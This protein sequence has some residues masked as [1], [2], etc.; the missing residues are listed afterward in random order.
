MET[1][2]PPIQKKLQSYYKLH[3]RLQKQLGEAI[4]DFSLINQGDHILIGL[5][6]GKDSLA[7]LN[8]LGERMSKS[9]H[10]FSLEAIHVRMSNIN[11]V[12]DASYLKAECDKWEIP[13]HVVETRFETDRDA[14]RTPCFLCSWNRR[15]V[16]CNEAQRCGCNKI[17][18]GH[19]QDDI[20]RTAL[21]NLTFCGTFST[22][23]VRIRMRK[24]D[25]TIIR[26]LARM[27]E[28]DLKQWAS[29]QHYQ[30]VKKVCPYDAASNR[31]N[32]LQ[33]TAALE[34]LTPDYRYNLWHALLKA[35]ALVEE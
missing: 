5:S 4:K 31:T 9:N 23:P 33:V 24:F 7:L 11:Y 25:M 35:G 14:K 30:P 10:Y 34:K 29:L 26:P 12:S 6:G 20:L 28:K 2:N 3:H 21:M 32:I 17:A 22:M 19:H 8:L 13:L 27:Q 16:L 1:N 15:K 18:L